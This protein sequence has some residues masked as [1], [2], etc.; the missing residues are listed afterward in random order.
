MHNMGFSLLDIDGQLM[1]ELLLL[2]LYL[3]EA[4]KHMNI[5]CLLIEL[6]KLSYLNSRSFNN[7]TSIGNYYIN[8]IFNIDYFCHFEENQT[9]KN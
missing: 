9:L 8:L 1:R 3:I 5:L 4:L 7:N 2:F 6:I